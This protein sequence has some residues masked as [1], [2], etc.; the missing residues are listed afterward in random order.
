MA[1]RAFSPLAVAGV[2]KKPITKT[3]K[4]ESAKKSALTSIH[5]DAFPARLLIDFLMISLFRV[6]VIRIE[7]LSLR[8]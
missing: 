2:N 3:R 7:P 1:A 8:F 6:F 5:G 4:S